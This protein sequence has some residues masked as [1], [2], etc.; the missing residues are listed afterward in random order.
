M[1]RSREIFEY[2]CSR[3]AKINLTKF[4]SIKDA[5]RKCVR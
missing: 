5:I 1:G 3:S 2:R 4:V